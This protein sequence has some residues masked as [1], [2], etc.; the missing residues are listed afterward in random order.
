MN[1]KIEK[2]YIG[3]TI[4]YYQDANEST[5]LVSP[6]QTKIEITQ[7]STPISTDNWESGRRY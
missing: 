3:E 1:T 5:T 6:T 2:V 4:V 7:T